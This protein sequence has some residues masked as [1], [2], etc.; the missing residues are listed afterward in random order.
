MT[1]SLIIGS[2]RSLLAQAQSTLVREMLLAAWET[3][4]SGVES[5]WN[6]LVT[7]ISYD[8]LGREWFRS[9]PFT[10]SEIGELSEF[11]LLGR[12]VKRWPYKLL[13]D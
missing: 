4:K 7:G 1:K 5:I 10:S 13:N 3:F 12:V 8:V 11:D 2:R 6:G 9:Y